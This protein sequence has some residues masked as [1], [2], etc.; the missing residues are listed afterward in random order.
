MGCEHLL[1]DKEKSPGPAL[2]QYLSD[3]VLHLDAAASW[4]SMF[5]RVLLVKGEEIF[6]FD[7]EAKNRSKWASKSYKYLQKIL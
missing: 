6:A 2:S 3:P 1:G 7:A 5:R 4:I